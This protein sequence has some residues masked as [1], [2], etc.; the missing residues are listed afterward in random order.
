MHCFPGIQSW[1][2]SL[3][4]AKR[5]SMVIHVGRSSQ[6]LFFHL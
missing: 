5:V 2:L 6:L 1:P 3:A 4:H